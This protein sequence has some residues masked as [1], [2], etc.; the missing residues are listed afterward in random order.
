M[1]P[2]LCLLL[3][4]LPMIAAAE[5]E[6]FYISPTGSDAHAG[7]SPDAPFQT[8]GKALESIAAVPRPWSS[9]VVVHVMPGDYFLESTIHL[10]AKHSGD[11]KHRLVL[12][13]HGELASAVLIGGQKLD[14][15]QW[16][17]GENGILHQ[18]LPE[19]ERIDII[20]Q[21]RRKARKARFP[22]CELLE[23]FPITDGKYFISGTVSKTEPWLT[24]QDKDFGKQQLAALGEDIQNKTDA[25]LVVWGHGT[26]DWH[27]WVYPITHTQPESGQIFVSEKKPTFHQGGKNKGCRYYVEGGLRY[28]DAPGEFHFD[29]GQRRLYYMPVNDGGEV[30]YSTMNNVLKLEGARNI[31]V[32][33][34]RFAC[35]GVLPFTDSSYTW[36]D[37]DA[38]VTVHDS[39]SIEILNCHF[40]ST[41]QSAINFESTHHS[42]IGNCL[43]QYL[44]QSGIKLYESDDNTIRNCLI[45]DIG[46]RRVYCEGLSV[47][48]SKNNAVSHL[49]IHN[50]ARYGITIRGRVSDAGNDRH[51]TMGNTF[52]YIRMQDV[53]QDSGDTAGLHM[54]KI[55]AENGREYINEF[56]QITITRSIAQPNITDEWKPTGVYLDHKK[57]VMNQSMRNIEVKDYDSRYKGYTVKRFNGIYGKADRTSAKQRQ[58]MQNRLWNNDS[59]TKF[60]CSWQDN[61]DPKHMEYEKIGLT[62]DFPDEY[63]GY[64]LLK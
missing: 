15:D 53:N 42:K 24:V 23:D 14:P 25:Y 6:N 51:P 49:E 21:D 56:D 12:R 46:L 39:Q 35:S 52:K 8:F 18:D 60:N 20:Y 26:C 38:A 11:G 16:K 13:N 58:I 64:R 63:S 1:I 43:M 44:G 62:D 10:T 36:T 5:P 33:G 45:H 40:K 29:R 7:K 48:C 22:N 55:N 27:K 54:A 3:A 61:F 9:D 41:G 57:S 19:V 30:I 28:L 32:D 37:P 50:S 17:R 59:S 2:R 31:R 4:L 47:H 34:L